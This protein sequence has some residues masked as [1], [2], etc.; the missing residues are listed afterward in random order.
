MR[1]PS[2]TIFYL[3]FQAQREIPSKQFFSERS[4]LGGI[5]PLMK[6]P[7]RGK[8]PPVLRP[9]PFGKGAIGGFSVVA[10]NAAQLIFI[11]CVVPTG[12]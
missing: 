2:E 9:A 8:N 1:I 5:A 7:I 4:D 3:S 10:L 6:M 12:A 11:C